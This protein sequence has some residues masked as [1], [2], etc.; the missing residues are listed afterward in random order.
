MRVAKEDGPTNF[1]LAASF[2]VLAFTQR[3]RGNGM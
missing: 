3:P 1:S 2:Y